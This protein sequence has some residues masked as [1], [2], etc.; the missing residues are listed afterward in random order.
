MPMRPGVVPSAADE[1]R[2]RHLVEHIDAL[3]DE[4]L[5]E[6]ILTANLTPRKCLGYK[7]P[8]Q[9]MLADLGRDV[10]IRFA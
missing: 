6:I 10:K 1:R 2:A 3:G 9:A 4:D 5:Q 8:I 7:T